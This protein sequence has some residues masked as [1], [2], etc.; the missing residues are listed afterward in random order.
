MTLRK[1]KLPSFH[2]GKPSWSAVLGVLIFFSLFGQDLDEV[3]SSLDTDKRS[4]SIAVDS[5]VI[6]EREKIRKVMEGS[7][8]KS[9][10]SCNYFFINCDVQRKNEYKS[11][12]T[13]KRAAYVLRKPL[14]FSANVVNSFFAATANKRNVRG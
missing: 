14:L 8:S 13:S 10:N 7:Y 3:H 9:F 12:S 6:K 1:S 11:N 5:G 2:A 4:G